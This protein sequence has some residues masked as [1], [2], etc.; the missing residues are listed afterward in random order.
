METPQQKWS[1][2]NTC[3]NFRVGD[4]VRTRGD[5]GRF[6]LIITKIHNDYYCEC[7]TWMFGK[8]RHFNMNCFKSLHA[9]REGER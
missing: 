3:E 1:L 7:K 2:D 6:N 9:E 5:M 8:K 4:Q